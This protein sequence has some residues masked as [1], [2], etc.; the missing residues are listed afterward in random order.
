MAEGLKEEENEDWNASE[1]ILTNL[2]N[3]HLNINE[4]DAMID[5]AHRGRSRWMVNQVGQYLYKLS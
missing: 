3:K 4:E 5:R 1:T 2:I